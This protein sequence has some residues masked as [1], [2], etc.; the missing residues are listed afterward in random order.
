MLKSTQIYYLTPEELV[1]QLEERFKIALG[2]IRA[3]NTKS[4]SE[5]LLTREQTAKLL[6]VS[7]PTLNKWSKLGILNSYHMGNRV[8]YKKQE[9]ISTLELNKGGEAA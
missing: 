9:I 1:N 6:S 2:S 5:E 7:L 3:E 8:Y 4:D